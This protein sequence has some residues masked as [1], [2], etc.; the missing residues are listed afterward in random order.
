MHFARYDRP[1]QDS[2]PSAPAF[3]S[4]FREG[5]MSN[6]LRFLIADDFS[7]MR[8]IV[9]SLLQARGAAKS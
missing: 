3:T 2:G 7:T 4:S 6:D 9:K 8:R 5:F 1:R